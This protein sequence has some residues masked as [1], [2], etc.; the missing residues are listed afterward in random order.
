MEEDL[1]HVNDFTADIRQGVS[2]IHLNGNAQDP[3]LGNLGGND[4]EI[5]EA[6]DDVN[7]SDEFMTFLEAFISNASKVKKSGSGK[8]KLMSIGHT[9]K[10][11]R[12]SSGWK[13]ILKRRS[14]SRQG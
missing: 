10:M 11:K 7:T 12:T 1:Y 2:N 6:N 13:F 5:D 8:W 4:S 14:G 9:L 3:V